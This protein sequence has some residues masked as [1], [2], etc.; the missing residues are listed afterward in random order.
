MCSGMRLYACMLACNILRVHIIR[1]ILLYMKHALT[2]NNGAL[3]RPHMR[4]TL[5]AVCGFVE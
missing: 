5:L 1:T 3:L 4:K 2:Y